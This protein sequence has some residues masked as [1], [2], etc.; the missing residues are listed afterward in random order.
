MYINNNNP[1]VMDVDSSRTIVEDYVRYRLESNGLTWQNGQRDVTPNEIQRAM[2]A[3]GDE[4]ESRFSQAFDDMIN[5]LHITTDTAYQTFRTIV[6]EIFSDGVNW[7]R[8]VALFGFGGKL[9]VRCVQQS[10]PQLVSSIVDW[11]STYVDTT[12]QSWISANNGWVRR[13]VFVQILFC[14]CCFSTFYP[15]LDGD[16]TPA[17]R[18]LHALCR[19]DD[20]I[21]VGRVH[22]VCTRID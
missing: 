16:A 1:S 7:G 14:C 18:L 12:L 21:D 2:R 9:A 4:F 11:V 17:C 8:V 20:T 19:A 6:N 5:Q 3:L 13:V 10:M 22:L 15:F